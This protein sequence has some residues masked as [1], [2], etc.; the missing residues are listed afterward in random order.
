MTISTKFSIE[1]IHLLERANFSWSNGENAFVEVRDPDKET[2]AEYLS[3]PPS[4]ISFE[5]MR[6]HGLLKSATVPEQE[7]GLQW[8]RKKLHI[9]G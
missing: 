4:K 2:T 1:A 3:R 6:D 5:E 7:L 8:L 9:D